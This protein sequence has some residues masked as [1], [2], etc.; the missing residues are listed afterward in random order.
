MDTKFDPKKKMDDL[1]LAI[2]LP[3]VALAVVIGLYFCLAG[4]GNVHLFGDEFHSIWH[5]NQSY[6]DILKIYDA[7]GSGVALPLIQ[8]FAVDIMGPGLWAYRLPAILGAIATLL[9]IYPA[10]SCMVGRVPAVLTALSLSTNS[11]FLFYCGFGRSY[12]LALFLAIVMAYAT[13]MT[14]ANTRP[15]PWWHAV[16]AISSGLLPYVH[17]TTVAFVVGIGMTAIVCNLIM[18]R[19]R[20]LAWLTGSL[21]VGAMICFLLYI[22]AW[23]GLWNFIHNKTG[24]GEVEHFAAF[25]VLD[26]LTGNR[27]VTMIWTIAIPIAIA[28]LALAR[29]R[30]GSILAFAVLVPVIA[31]VV[32][33]PAGMTYAYARYLLPALPFMI[34]LTFWLF[35]EIIRLT[36]LPTPAVHAVSLILGIVLIAISFWAG[37]RGAEHTNDGP[38]ANTYIGM[39]PLPA[40]DVP[41]DGTPK[42]YKQLAEID[43]PVRIIEVPELRSRAVILYRNYYL[44]HKKDVLIGMTMALKPNAEVP[45][46]PYVPIKSAQPILDSG[47]DYLI[48]HLN[49]DRELNWYWN[50]VYNQAWPK[51]KD[52]NIESLM[53]RQKKY[54]KTLVPMDTIAQYAIQA[55]GQ[56]IYKDHDI[57]VWKLKPEH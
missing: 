45:A 30:S 51:M 9:V 44:Q 2:A 40:F 8:R 27:V 48:I 33:Q 13:V 14:L 23:D 50:F 25:D 46:G 42:F 5:L 15:K 57:L 16:L 43:G 1:P 55:M 47:A 29:R 39:M 20:D 7:H 24:K 12:L 49:V 28:G 19:Y 36:R 6:G 34:M 37:P 41:W 22:P 17:L 18:K 52:P 4:R 11:L 35:V 31:L 53:I 21:A 38:F 10:A 26:L 56:P 3:L 54:L 32:T